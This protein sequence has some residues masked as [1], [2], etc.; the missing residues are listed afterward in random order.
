MRTKK[1]LF[2][3]LATILGGCIPIMSIDPFYTSSDVVFEEKLLGTWADDTN[4]P[5]TT[6]IFSRSEDDPNNTYKLIF[7]DEKGEKGLFAAHLVKLQDNLFLDLYPV[8]SS[9]EMDDSNKVDYPYGYSLLF[10][11]PVHTILK[12]D[13]IEPQLILRLTQDEKIKELLKEHPDAA[14]YKEIEGRIVLTAPT[15]EL[16]AFV[17]KYAED[18]RLFPDK[19]ILEHKTDTS[20]KP[21]TTIK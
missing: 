8:E 18:E 20:S 21:G 5:N 17:L 15:K 16:Q 6:W 13:S 10:M 12:V 3:A 14:D 4:D 11:L 7:I 1:V 9:S 19:I 2:Y